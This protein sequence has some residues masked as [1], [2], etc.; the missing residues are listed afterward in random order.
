M[1]LKLFKTAWIAAAGALLPALAFAAPSTTLKNV[2]I[3]ADNGGV[4]VTLE[5]SARARHTLFTL[6]KPYRIVIDLS[7]TKAAA[8]LRI[9]DGIGAVDVIRTGVRPN[10]TLRV[11]LQLKSAAGSRAE[12]QPAF[13]DVGDR[14]VVAIGTKSFLAGAFPA[15][16]ARTCMTRHTNGR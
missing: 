3:T 8:G 2:S 4:R 13:A 16:P 5:T 10:E 1:I 15:S 7:D 12:W 6:Q 11:V 14:F 9:P